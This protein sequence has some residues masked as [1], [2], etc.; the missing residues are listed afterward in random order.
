MILLSIDASTD[1]GIVDSP[2]RLRHFL[3]AG[4]GDYTE[5]R[6]DWAT[7]RSIAYALQCTTRVKTDPRVQPNSLF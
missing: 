3:E 4:F 1:P 2:P 6:I 7:A 5:E